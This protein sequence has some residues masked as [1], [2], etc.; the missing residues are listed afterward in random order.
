[1]DVAQAAVGLL[2]V[3]LEQEGDVAV[4][5]VAF[6]DLGRQHRKPLR[7]VAPPLVQRR[8]QHGLGHRRIAG[9]H[10]AVEQ[11]ELGSEVPLGHL[12]DLGGAANGVVEADAFVPHRVPDGIGDATDVPATLVDQHDVEVAV[13]AELAASVSPHGDEHDSTRI[14]VG[15]LLEQARQPLVGGRREGGAEGL[16]LEV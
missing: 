16:A 4:G 5:T 11:P 10:P 3:G 9:H 8:S 1:M 6:V 15:G 13:G 12:E 7:G 14:P 2:Q